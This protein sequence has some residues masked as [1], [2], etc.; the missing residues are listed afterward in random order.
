M[1]ICFTAM[2]ASFSGTNNKAGNAFGVVFLYLFV[3]FYAS[4]FDACSYVYCSEIFPTGMRA[5]GVAASIF[6]LFSMTLLYTEAASTA[7]ANIGW[8]YYLV[9]IIV[10]ACGL[11]ILARFPETRGLSLEEISA[12]FGDEVALDLT[13]MK[14]MEKTRLD[15]E[16][17]EGV[18][19][20][21]LYEIEVAHR[22]A[23]TVEVPEKMVNAISSEVE[24]V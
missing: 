10:P 6:G 13:H 2:V 8:K 3:T 12:V 21:A 20:A 19:S 4:C 1:L 14:T 7:F 22:K 5:Q 11:P 24:Y 9:F 17:R 23:S 15:N 16:L 18:D